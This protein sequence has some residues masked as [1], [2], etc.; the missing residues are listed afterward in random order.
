MFRRIRS[1]FISGILLLAPLGVTIFVINILFTKLGTPTRNFFFFFLD[2]E[3]LE[4]PWLANALNAASILLLA[5]GLTLLGWFSNLLI[6]R[7]FVRIFDRMVSNMPIIRNIYTTVKQIVDTFGQQQ[8]AVF[9]K[10]VLLEYPRKDCWVV[11]FVTS[12]GKGEVQ[13][14]TNAHIVNIFVPTTP[15]PTSGFLLML[16]SSD[17]IEL[18]MSISEAMKL[19][20]SGGAVV[21]PYP[22]LPKEEKRKKAKALND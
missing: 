15:N 22:P 14:R 17:I 9:Q 8:K 13:E 12:Q 20:I 4:V 10:A 2:K 5:I 1:S 11:G 6:G 16:P 21:P 19:V 18:E 3:M 7:F